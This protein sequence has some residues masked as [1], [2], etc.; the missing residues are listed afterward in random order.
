MSSKKGL[1][2][3]EHKIKA[4]KAKREDILKMDPEDALN[5]IIDFK[6]NIPLV[7]S[8]PEQSLY[9]LMNEAG[10]EDFLPILAMASKKQWEYIIDLEIWNR[11]EIDIKQASY[12]LG[13]MD[14]ADPVRL[15]NWLLEEQSDF[16][17]YFLRNKIDVVI[18]EHDEDP[19]IIPDDFIT[20][21]DVIYFKVLDDQPGEKPFMET[22]SLIYDLL[23]RIAD[24]SYPMYQTIIF[25]SAGV[26]NA[27]HAENLYRERNSRLEGKGLL[28]LDEAIEIYAPFIKSGLKNRYKDV[29][30]SESESSAIDDKGNIDSSF[31]MN[32]FSMDNYFAD[33]ETF[34]S[35]FISLC[36]RIIVADKKGVKTRGDLEHIAKRVSGTLRAGAQ[37]IAGLT[38]KDT[39]D[40]LIWNIFSKYSLIDVFKAGNTKIKDVREKVLKWQR[41]SWLVKNSLQIS[42]LGEKWF[43]IAGGML[44]WP[45]VYFNN[46]K[47]GSQIYRPF[48]SL[49]EIMETE[50]EIDSM[51]ALDDLFALM[52]I[53]NINIK[54][55]SLGWENFILTLWARD[56]LHMK[57]DVLEPVSLENFRKFFDWLWIK[58]DGVR[59]I[60]RDKKQDFLNWLVRT[61]EI[62]P[63]LLIGKLGNVFDDLFELLE[64]EY[65]HVETKSLDA[66]YINFFLVKEDQI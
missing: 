51:A 14:M 19:S 15:A 40:V 48:N 20:F 56:W 4:L 1:E 17:S 43:G 60:G 64:N 39:D 63:D 12:W 31:L 38:D 54:E 24:K 47:K 10:H 66:K 57:D 33:T 53:K 2:I 35:E 28:P 46:Y 45:P 61:A 27:E 30:K 21:D 59:F 5:E 52:G 25:I 41:S 22:K 6:E 37:I 42:F 55:F 26:I 13:L 23:S 9:M 18:R 49:D 3:V 16:L 62:E 44:V 7:H 50:S 34:S 58:E 8:F 29:L 32:V 11:D 36:N 65:R